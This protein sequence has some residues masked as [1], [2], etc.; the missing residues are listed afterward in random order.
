MRPPILV[1][2]QSKDRAAELL[3]ELRVRGWKAHAIHSGMPQADRDEAMRKL[4]TGEL[5]A[6]VRCP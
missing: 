2:V 3:E 1:F 6:L 4:R 5:W